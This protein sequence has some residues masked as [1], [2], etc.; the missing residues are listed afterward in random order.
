MK[1]VQRLP[2]SA[3]AS[4]NKPSFANSALVSPN[5]SAKVCR[6][7]PQPDEHASFKYRLSMSPFLIWKHLMS[8]PPMSMIKSTSGRN[9]F[10]AV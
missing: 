8:C 2:K 3:G 7:E 10:A 1:T 4:A 6:N 9:F 5:V